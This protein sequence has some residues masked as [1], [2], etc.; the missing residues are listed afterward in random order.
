MAGK[1]W[2]AGQAISLADIALGPIVHRCLDFPVDAAGAA[3]A[4]RPGARSLT[5]RPAFKKATG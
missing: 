1:P 2:V 3:A 5:E 4:S